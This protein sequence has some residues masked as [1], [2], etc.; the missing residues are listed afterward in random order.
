MISSLGNARS[1]TGGLAPKCP[2]NLAP[3]GSR[4]YCVD[5][6]LVETLLRN[7]RPEDERPAELLGFSSVT[8]CVD[9][10]RETLVRDCM[11]IDEERGELN[12][13]NWTFA[14]IGKGKLV[15]GAHEEFAARERNH[16][17]FAF[18]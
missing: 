1:R 15:I 2:R 18:C 14:I 13:A 16:I 4:S 11:P 8:S 7:L 9:K 5:H 10:V 6:K 17:E 3:P 12:F